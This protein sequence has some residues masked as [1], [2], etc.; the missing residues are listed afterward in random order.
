[1]K[2]LN[3]QGICNALWYGGIPRMLIKLTGN[4]A[5]A[6]DWIDGSGNTRRIYVCDPGD[7]FL[8]LTFLCG[9]YGMN[10]EHMPEIH[11][12]YAYAFFWLAVAGIVS[13]LLLIMRRRKWL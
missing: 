9:V 13:T 5:F 12:K 10:F 8:P 11:W 2:V 7:I 4:G 6:A 3:R 1:M